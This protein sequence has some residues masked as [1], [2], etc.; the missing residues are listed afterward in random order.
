MS[1][2]LPL[3][4]QTFAPL[5]D[6]W[7]VFETLLCNPKLVYFVPTFGLIQD[8]RRFNRRS[9]CHHDNNC[10]GWTTDDTRSE[11]W[12]LKPDTFHRTLQSWN[13][14]GGMVCQSKGHIGNVEL[15]LCYIMPP[16]LIKLLQVF[17]V[18]KIGIFCEELAALIA[19]KSQT[20]FQ[21][22]PLWHRI[23]AVSPYRL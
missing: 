20:I 5:H 9:W 16:D 15:Q 4:T 12:A 2:I 14:L 6:A 21:R 11:C 13:S 1:H 19:F 3:R 23:I 22:D 17:I 7:L 18:F 8:N 10:V